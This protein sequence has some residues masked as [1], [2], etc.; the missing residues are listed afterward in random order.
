[1][2]GRLWICGLAT[3]AASTAGP[4]VGVEGLAPCA[5]PNEL[6]PGV[7]L[8]VE[9]TTVT[10][11]SAVFT[12]LTCEGGSPSPADSTV[13]YNTGG[14]GGTIIA[15]GETAFHNITI[16]SLEPGTTY[17][18]E[19]S[20]NGIAGL[21]DRLNPGVFTTLTPPPG[22]LLF[23]FAVIADTHIGETVSGLATSTPDE[24][25][26]AYRSEV[27]YAEVMMASAI[28]QINKKNLRMT[29]SVA[30][31][32]THGELEHMETTH[33]LLERLR[34]AY[35]TARGPHDRP[36]QYEEATADCGASGDCFRKVFRPSIPLTAP[37]TKLPQVRTRRGWSLIALDSTNL[38]S[39]SG[40]IGEE[41]LAWL[42]RRLEADKVAGRR[43]I[44]FFHHPVAEYSTTIAVPP[45]VFGIPIQ[46]A[47]TFLRLIS[48]YDVALVVNSHT[49]RN[50]IAYSD[51][52]GSTPLIEVGP[53]KEYPGGYTVIR[54]YEGGLMRL[55]FPL[56][57]GFCNEWRETTRGEYFAL[58]PLY[59]AGSLRDRNFVHLFDGPDRPGI[60]SVPTGWWPPGVPGEA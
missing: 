4:A 38:E 55:W 32:T 21:P 33:R 45:A 17:T 29:V 59:T 22:E 34:G 57:C 19:V 43:A 40:E 16:D 41:Q 30:D 53:T 8:N 49:H 23:S 12:W 50:W 51:I 28:S 60:P 9:L 56:D 48:E 44:I 15:A 6:P 7:P 35:L 31:T 2:R 14:S 52:T 3:L 1:M 58:Y 5:R 46:E 42:Q 13:T 11:T 39:G 27:P 36:N 54:V 47:R 18:Y 20:S 24:L 37:P 10:D 26:P 25:P